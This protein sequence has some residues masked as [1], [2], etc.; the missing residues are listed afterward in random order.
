MGDDATGA[1][2]ERLRDP[3]GHPAIVDE[4]AVVWRADLAALLADYDRR[5][6]ERDT[7]RE[8]VDAV[9]ALCDEADRETPFGDPDIVLVDVDRVRAALAPAQE[10][11]R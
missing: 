6:Q 9:E 4:C 7:A 3:G 11:A 8:A 10:V 5:G 2:V 1:A